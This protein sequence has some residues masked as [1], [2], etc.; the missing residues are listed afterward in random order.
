[1]HNMHCIYAFGHI[2]M[3]KT[4]DNSDETHTHIHTHAHSGF[5]SRSFEPLMRM[6]LARVKALANARGIFLFVCA[7]FYIAVTCILF[8][9]LHVI[10]VLVCQVFWRLSIFRLCENVS[11]LW[12]LAHAVHILWLHLYNFL[13]GAVLLLLYDLHCLGFWLAA[14]WIE[15]DW[16]NPNAKH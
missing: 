11:Y 7:T 14:Y 15:F 2:F 16:P 1:M 12:T 9:R 5:Y 3:K 13:A 4:K 6:Y 10:F 8:V